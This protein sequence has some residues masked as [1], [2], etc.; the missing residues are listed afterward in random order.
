L[1]LFV[2]LSFV[3]FPTQG[4][5]FGLPGNT[6][7]G[8]G[9]L[10][11]RP[12]TEQLVGLHVAAGGKRL[13]ILANV[14]DIPHFQQCVPT[15]DVAA[16]NVAI[17]RDK[18]FASR[19]SFESPE[20]GYSGTYRFSGRFVRP[21]EAAGTLRVSY[22]ASDGTTACDATV[23]WHAWAPRLGAGSGIARGGALYG[24]ITSQRSGT[25][26]EV[27]EPLLLELAG[28]GRRVKRIAAPIDNRC[29]NGTRPG[30]RFVFLG[31]SIPIRSGSFADS[32]S[33]SVPLGSGQTAEL[34][35]T[36]RGS[37]HRHRVSGTWR[38]SIVIRDDTSGAVL[39]RCGGQLNRWQANR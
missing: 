30:V 12:G 23:R 21:D 34:T 36:V 25:V 5:A 1:L 19:G 16:R 22:T 10:P 7:Y 20:L 4:A 18:T 11:P 37:F 9:A 15:P 17:H 28:N 2:V 6:A 27:Q 31:L 39:D 32:S 29:K 14:V 35:S 38:T 24:G 3:T 13:T 8:G 26:A 33:A